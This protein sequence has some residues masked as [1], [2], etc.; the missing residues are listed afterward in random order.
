MTAATALPGGDASSFAN[1]GKSLIFVDF[2][3]HIVPASAVDAFAQA[4][5]TAGD[6]RDLALQFASQLAAP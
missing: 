6:D 1:Q 2:L 4:G 5:R 3:T